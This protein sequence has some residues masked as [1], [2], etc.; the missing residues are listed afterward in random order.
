MR[1]HGTT[2][3]YAAE[4]CRCDLC[5]RA[6]SEYVKEWKANRYGPRTYGKR[7]PVRPLFDAAETTTVLELARLTDI[8]ART[9]HR[10]MNAGISDRQADRVAVA[11]G[12]HPSLIWTDW[13]DIYAREAA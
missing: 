12:L 2:T 5:R 10:W 7:W 1:Q 4:K 3:K 11:L 9:I 6:H 13:F 8:P